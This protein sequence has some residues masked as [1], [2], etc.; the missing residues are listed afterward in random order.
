MAIDRFSSVTF[1]NSTDLRADSPW[2]ADSWVFVYFTMQ[3]CRRS[4][5]RA[6]LRVSTQHMQISISLLTTRSNTSLTIIIYERIK[7]FAPLDPC[8]LPLSIY[9]VQI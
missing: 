4:S 6:N 5:L 7:T 2:L 1:L 3:V 8:L 9:T